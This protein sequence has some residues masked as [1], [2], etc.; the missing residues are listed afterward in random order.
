M[1]L[2]PLCFLLLNNGLEEVVG[3]FGCGGGELVGPAF[4]GDHAEVV[5]DFADDAGL[6]PG[7]TFGGVLSGGFVKLPTALGEDPATTTCGLDEKH[8]VLV[9]GERNY[10]RD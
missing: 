4:L 10:A 5:A 8:I 2:G 9:G 3:G 1:H 6:F 7:F